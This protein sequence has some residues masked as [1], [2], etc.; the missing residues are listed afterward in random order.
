MMPKM[1]AAHQQYP[2]ILMMLIDSDDDAITTAA[3]IA[4]NQSTFLGIVDSSKRIAGSYKIT[5][6]PTTILI[7]TYGSMVGRISGDVDQ[8]KLNAYLESLLMLS[9]PQ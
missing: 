4:A 7:N 2:S 9:S 6:V 5:A 1:A 3:F 8:K